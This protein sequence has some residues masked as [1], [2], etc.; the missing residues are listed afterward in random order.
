MQ[1]ADTVSVETRS[2]NM[3][4]IKGK[5]TVPEVYFRHLLFSRGLR[6]RLNVSGI[7]GHPDIYLAKYRTAVFVNGCFWHRHHNCRF[8]YTPKSNTDFWNAK[9]ERNEQRDLEV[10]DQLGEKGYR[11][12]VVWECTL[13]K[14]KKD[15]DTENRIIDEVI[16]FLNSGEKNREF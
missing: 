13:K 16:C 6:Y 8:A 3:A 1:M 9:F 12:L 7:P 11:Q 15:H 14:M 2:R 10:R 5:N 4:A